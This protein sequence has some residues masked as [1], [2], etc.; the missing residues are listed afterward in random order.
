MQ[1]ETSAGGC[2]FITQLIEERS[3]WRIGDKSEGK[4][5]IFEVKF[6]VIYLNLVSGLDILSL[7]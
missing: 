2:V 6:F 3:C 7:D 4:R 1:Q 5:R